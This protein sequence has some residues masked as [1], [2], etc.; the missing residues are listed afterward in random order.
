MENGRKK[1]IIGQ[2][3]WGIDDRNAD[4]VAKQIKI[5]MENR[6]VA[7]LPLLDSANRQVTVYFNASIAPAV[8]VDLDLGPPKPTEIS[9]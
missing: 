4:E 1:V 7:A 9:G 6:T 2:S 5:A 8:V 3:E